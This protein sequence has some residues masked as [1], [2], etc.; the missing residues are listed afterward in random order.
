M[1]HRRMKTRSLLDMLQEAGAPR[2][3]DYFSLDVESMEE[4]ALHGLLSSG[5]SSSYRIAVLSIENPSAACRRILRRAGLR[6][7]RTLGDFGE[8][9]WIDQHV[10]A[11]RLTQR[12]TWAPLLKIAPELQF[13]CRQGLNAEGPCVGTCPVMVEAER[14]R[15]MCAQRLACRWFTYNELGECYLRKGAHASSFDYSRPQSVSCRK[16]DGSD[17]GAWR[18]HTWP[19]SGFYRLADIVKCVHPHMLQRRLRGRAIKMVKRSLGF[20]NAGPC[21]FRFGD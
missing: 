3:I 2:I 20:C 10:L 21:W 19:A 6:F 1:V 9:L 14:C 16:L 7:N 5:S 4:F 17:T 11:E 13:T 18:H 8:E 15:A 12:L